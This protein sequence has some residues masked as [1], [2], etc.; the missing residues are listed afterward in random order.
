MSLNKSPRGWVLGGA[1]LLLSLAAWLAPAWERRGRAQALAR[2][3]W[4][5]FE[6][7]SKLPGFSHILA[8]AADP[9]GNVWVNTDAG[10][11]RYD[12][13]GW[14]SYTLDEAPQSKEPH[15]LVDAGGRVWLA[16]QTGATVIT[17]CGKVKYLP[18]APAAEFSLGDQVWSR[19]AAGFYCAY[20]LDKG[21]GECLELPAGCDRLLA[22]QSSGTVWA[23]ETAPEGVLQALCKVQN[24]KLTVFQLPERS[25]LP[26]EPALAFD[27]G[28]QPWLAQAGSGEDCCSLAALDGES[29]RD[30]KLDF[31]HFTNGQVAALAFDPQGRVWVLAEGNSLGLAVYDQETWTV[32][33]LADVFGYG[34]SGA[35]AVLG[36]DNQ[37]HVWVG[38]G[39][40]LLRL[41]ISGGLPPPDPLPDW[42]PPLLRR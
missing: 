2:A 38:R 5:T 23:G 39:S 11:L 40:R 27:A 18:D 41:D 31:P 9:T 42:L 20:S 8:V 16:A 33:D 17:P 32:Y 4:T 6:V 14:L 19:Q 7:G 36:L 12:G 21:E 28:G 26:G 30:H 1:L 29:W 37:G 22:L 13:L 34:S 25:A 35:S 15:M 10:L 3:G 24:S